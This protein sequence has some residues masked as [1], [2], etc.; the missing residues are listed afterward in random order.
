MVRVLVSSPRGAKHEALHFCCCFTPF[1]HGSLFCFS[2]KL[3]LTC[4][5][6]PPNFVS[7]ISFIFFV[8]F[9]SFASYY[10][11]SQS[12]FGVPACLTSFLGFSLHWFHIFLIYVSPFYLFIIIF[13]PCSRVSPSNR[14]LRRS[15]LITSRLSIP[16]TSIFFAPF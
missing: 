12:L 9:Y 2:R 5:F 1:H 11:L 15:F 3:K 7:F 10:V 16:R 8:L 4:V 6:H 14:S 13:P